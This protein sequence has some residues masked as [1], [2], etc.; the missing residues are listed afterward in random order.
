MFTLP[1]TSS[2]IRQFNQILSLANLR[3]T[4]CDIVATKFVAFLQYHQTGR[5]T[6]ND[7]RPISRNK[8]CLLAGGPVLLFRRL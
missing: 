2:L 6:A 3:A 5:R 1:P 4:A 8:T 7:Q